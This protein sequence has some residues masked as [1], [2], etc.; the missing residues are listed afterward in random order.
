MTQTQVALKRAYFDSSLANLEALD[1]SHVLGELA[2][3]HEHALESQQ[4][5]AW[6]QQ[7][8]HL[9]R[10]FRGWGEGHIFLEFA[11]PRMGKRADVVVITHG[12]VFVIE[13]KVG[14]RSHDSAGEE[15][16]LDY[17]LDLKNFHSGSHHT[18]VVPVLVA[19][20]AGGVADTP[21]WFE[22]QVSSVLKANDECLRATLE[23]AIGL[24]HRPAIDPKAWERSAYKP[25][26]TIVQAARALYEGH[27][28]TEITRSDA[29]AI[30]LSRTADAIAALIERAKSTRQK[31]VCFVTGVPGSGKTLAGLNLA[32][33]R[34]RVH[35]D[36]HA[37]FLS[38]NDPLVDVLRE[39]LARDEVARVRAGGGQITK[40]QAAKKAKTF[41]QTIRHF[42]DESLRDPEAPVERVVVFDEAQRAWT[43]EQVARF[44]LRKRGIA[45]F[46]MS[47]PQFLL[48]VMNRHVGWCLVVCLV[49]GGQEINTG[50]AG[51][52]EWFKA[53][54]EHF[55]D[56]LAAYSPRALSAQYSWNA[57]LSS[58]AKKVQTE[59]MD[60][61]NLNVS[62]RSFR[63]ERVSAFVAAVLDDQLEEARGERQ[64]LER[65]P[66]AI[67][68]DLECAR[69]WL[70]ARARG[71]ER[72]GLVASSNALRLKAMRLHAKVKIDAPSW[73]LN[74]KEDVRSSFLLEDVATEFAVQGLELD[75]VGVCWDAN[76]RHSDGGWTLHAFSGTTWKAVKRDDR[77]A[78]LMNT[79]RVLLTRARQGM[80]IYLPTGCLR[81]EGDPAYDATRAPS[82]YDGTYEF[83]LACGIPEGH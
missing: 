53:L 27:S 2:R 30:N 77:R 16:V 45:D 60:D 56:W 62:V 36:E 32:T 4:K 66:M 38:G 61:L 74:E 11:I 79:Y 25:T 54:G 24:T 8:R 50:E 18:P 3:Q 80:V 35:E 51:L 76:L 34:M 41:I 7:I 15:Q 40:V 82:F 14:A 23:N 43:R 46:G 68:R 65:Y 22:D 83:L 26:P 21:R 48:S 13:Y 6:I 55:P 72:Y 19:T 49:G 57:D 39:A 29:G 37:V 73:F 63:A 20:H 69:N 9:K 81:K 70:R 47:E 28:V 78:Y 64:E 12:I 31:I 52:A 1:E 71:S 33:Q 10:V 67:T 5:N 17:A 75:W 44:M 58:L 59:E 42:R